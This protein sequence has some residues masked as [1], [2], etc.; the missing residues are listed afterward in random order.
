MSVSERGSINSVEH[1]DEET[2]KDDSQSNVEAKDVHQDEDD[3]LLAEG[4]KEGTG[5]L[6]PTESETPLGEEIH[7]PTKKGDA[8]TVG[9]LRRSGRPP[10][11]TDKARLNKIEELTRRFFADYH[12]MLKVLKETNATLKVS[13]PDYDELDSKKEDIAYRLESLRRI[14]E[15]IAEIPTEGEDDSVEAAFENVV[16]SSSHTTSR[17][18]AI[19]ATRQNREVMSQLTAAKRLG[20]SP[21]SRTSRKSRSSTTSSKRIAVAT[22]TAALKERLRAQKEESERQRELEQLEMEEA[23]RQME[24]ETRRK[25]ANIKMAQKRRELEE[26]RLSAQLKERQAA[27]KVLE[28]EEDRE[29]EDL[30]TLSSSPSEASSCMS[31]R[32]VSVQEFSRTVDLPKGPVQRSRAILTDIKRVNSGYPV[33]ESQLDNRYTLSHPQPKS[34]PVTPRPLDPTRPA[35]QPTPAPQSSPF[36]QPNQLSYDKETPIEA[37]TRTMT[38]SRLPIPEPPVFTGDP[39]QYPDWISSF[40]SLIEC[41]GLPP[42]EK[43]HYLKRYLGG[44]A[45]EAVSGFFLLRS[46]NA[47][48]QA[49]LILEKR[50]GNRFDISEA[51]RTKLESWLKI[52]ARDLRG[53]QHLSDFL[54]QCVVAKAEIPELHIL[55]DSREIKKVA[56][57]LPPHMVHRWNRTSTLTKQTNGRYPSFQE[58]ATFVANETEI[59]TDPMTIHD[60][61]KSVKDN[62][63]SHQQSRNKKSTSLP[64]RVTLS[65][66]SQ[67]SSSSSDK[68]CLFCKRLNHIIDDCREFS[69]KSMD[70]RREFVKS[71][72]LCFGCLNHGHMSKSC[73][74]RSQCKKCAKRHPTSL[75]DDSL[76]QRPPNVVK[77]SNDKASSQSPHAQDSK[78]RD[79]TCREVMSDKA[80]S[81]T[82]MVVPVYVSSLESPSHEVLAYALLDT[83]SDTTFIA[84]GISRELRTSSDPAT[85]RLTTMTNQN[86]AI[87]CRKFSSLVVRGF[88][89]DK[90]IQLPPTYSRE[91]IPLDEDHIP[92]PE[93]ANQWPHLSRLS[94]FFVPKQ[95]CPVGLLIGYNCPTALAPRNCALGNNNE[96]FAVETELGWSIVGGSHREAPENFDSFGQTH[97]TVSMEVKAPTDS[98]G[99]STVQYVYKPTIKETTT[100][101]FLKLIERDFNDDDSRCMSQ[102]DIKFTNIVT[103]G[104][105]QR[106]DGYYEMPLPFKDEAPALPDNRQAA[107]HRALGLRKQFKKKPRYREHYSAFMEEILARGDAEKIPPEELL[108]ETRWYIPHHGVYHP[109][110]P[111][112]VRVVF[113]CS[114]RYQSISLNDH[115]LPGPDLI[116]PLV[117][118]LC[119]FREHPIALTC[120]V[121]KM[122]HQFRVN[123]EHQNYLRFLWWET[124]DLSEPPADYRM[125]VHL[126]G[127]VSSPACAN[128]ALKQLAKDHQH[129]GKEASEFLRRDFY[130]D[131]GLKSE[132]TVESMKKLIH[133]AVSICGKGN[134]RLHKII[135]NSPEVMES[136]PESER[137]NSTKAN[138][139]LDIDNSSP[140]KVLGLQWCI[141]SDSFCFK[142]DLKD[143]PLTRRG[144]LATVASVYD[145]LGLVAPL[146]L[147]GRKILKKMC[148]DK[149]DWDHP[150]PDD[151]RPEWKHWREEVRK[152]G[153]MKVLRCLSPKD[154]GQIASVQLHHFSDASLTGYGQCSY[155]RLIN[156]EGRVHCALVMAKARVSPSK[157]VTVPRLELQAATISTKV[158]RFLG[159]EMSYKNISH[160]FWTDSK[161]VLGYIR[162]ETKRFQ[163]FV[164]NRVQKIRQDSEPHQWNYISTEENPA[165]HASRGLTSAELVTTNWLR[166]PCFLWENEVLPQTTDVEIPADDPEVKEAVVHSV[167]STD[168][169]EFTSFEERL[170]KFS[171]WTRVTTA[172][173]TIL[174]RC[175]MT[176]GISLS[177]LEIRKKSEWNL[178]RLIQEESFQKERRQIEGSSTLD[179]SSPL[180]QLDPFIDE[181]GLLRVGGRLRRASM[182]YGVRHPII[183][184]RGSHLSKLVALHHHQKTAHQGRNLT[185]NEIR[186]CGFWI[187]GCRRIVSSLIAKCVTCTRFRGKPRGQKMADLPK[188]RLEASPPFTYCGLDC[189]GPFLVKEGR[190]ELKKYGLILTCLAMRAIHIEVLDDMSSDSFLNSLRCFIALRGK[191][192]LIRCDQG[193]N[194]VGAKHELK[195]N[196]KDLNS[197]LIANKLLDF[198]CEFQLNPP[199]SS[200]MGGIWERQIRNVRN[201]LN[202]ILDESSNQLNTSSLRTFMYEAMAIVN[203]RPLT[204][205]NLDSPDGPTPLTPN[206]VLTMKSGVVMPPPPGK[207]EKED[208]YLKKRWRRVQFLVDLFWTRWK[209]EYLHTLQSRKSWTEIQRN[210][211]VDDIVILRDDGLCRTDWQMAKVVEVFPS[212]DGLVRKVKLLMATAELDKKGKPLYKRTVLERPVHKLIV[213]LSCGD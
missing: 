168:S 19:F 208:L 117:G 70:E 151:L 130:V 173:S 160:H 81:L 170:R 6:L 96:P 39:L 174:A 209:K 179:K 82:S 9:T 86:A 159:V 106:D 101:D 111:D 116:N 104:I 21:A 105:H 22:E 164:A 69:R 65:T 40:T 78:E 191:V 52:Q 186:S 199:S 114:A 28:E 7:S 102:Q 181:H 60:T 149:L 121:E 152:L 74:N 139:S 83:M 202:G 91:Y 30:G 112:K 142:L 71:Q 84:E 61:D 35:F 15:E 178:V 146:V 2:F 5:P 196:L 79:A 177:K 188:E 120:D 46:E 51:F 10:K 23:A 206:H 36:L 1:M 141:E 175:L 198:D 58:F 213:L 176:K 63:V 33:A 171:S 157:Q 16:E 17:I 211:C 54:Q 57:K 153:E 3:Q 163:M 77:D 184:P 126:F 26:S 44:P 98:E 204:A 180:N 128:F 165:D 162:N 143:H 187:V 14:A 154:F 62:R 107:L 92:T 155:A 161:V 167:I 124:D 201:V 8:H 144:M 132:S 137:G 89:S 150:I 190:K 59:A 119:R 94:N 192:R 127:A 205:E 108:S 34:S 158:A 129:L 13:P 166:G 189:F 80:G 32:G 193:S 148:Q 49:K 133:Q 25:E 212:E 90:R 48:E 147:V 29:N 37:L 50:F 64:Q 203:S 97:R 134:L 20:T 131:D 210:V 24:E 67:R 103:K 99:P 4:Q 47:F 195:E 41:R 75:H 42:A 113:D 194:F 182:M 207:F 138:L 38:L 197:S 45:K 55:D 125:K 122:F 72:G 93:T 100:S 88:N 135:S 109:K 68:T 12:Q 200:H 145:P 73:Q 31:A 110:K 172:F 183:L 43:I 18:V 123:V 56:I 85:L 136:I 95:D 140:E 53:L 118:V 156:E 11:L 87:S 27:L 115:L 66:S 76:V 185:I 169:S